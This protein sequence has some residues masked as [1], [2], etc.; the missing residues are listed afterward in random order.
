MSKQANFRKLVGKT[1]AIYDNHGFPVERGV[2]EYVSTEQS[3]QQGRSE[4]HYVNGVQI[5]LGSLRNVSTDINLVFIDSK[6]VARLRGR[7]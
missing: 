2:L 5:P 4:G 7:G 1:I 6:Y 3:R